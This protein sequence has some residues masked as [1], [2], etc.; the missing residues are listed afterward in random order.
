MIAEWSAFFSLCGLWRFYFSCALPPLSIQLRDL[1][2]HLP[3]GSSRVASYCWG[4]QIH[5]DKLSHH[6]LEGLLRVILWEVCALDIW[7]FIKSSGEQKWGG[8]QTT[9][10]VAAVTH[11]PLKR[12]PTFGTCLRAER[13]VCLYCLPRPIC[14]VTWHSSDSQ[15][16]RLERGR[17]GS[18]TVT[19]PPQ[20]HMVCEGTDCVSRQTC[21]STHR[22]G[23]MHGRLPCDWLHIACCICFVTSVTAYLILAAFI[24]NWGWNSI[25]S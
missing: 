13:P 20:C 25:K 14:S 10:E 9:W 16:C 15:S 24:E 4:F 12:L 8:C 3:A 18:S 7:R 2:L 6:S 5:R 17:G 21:Q 23:L 1:Y 22:F 19:P 11:K